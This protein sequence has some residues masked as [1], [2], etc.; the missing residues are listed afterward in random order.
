MKRSLLLMLLSVFASVASGADQMRFTHIT[1]KDGLPNNTV[2]CALR[3]HK[4]YFWYGTKNGLCKWDGNNFEVFASTGKDSLSLPSSNILALFEDSSK[5]LW[6]ATNGGVTIYNRLMGTFDAVPGEVLA[7]GFAQSADGVIYVP[8]PQGVKYYDTEKRCFISLFKTGELASISVFAVAIDAG[9]ALWAGTAK[10]LY[11]IDLKTMQAR[12]YTRAQGLASDNISA[13][14]IDSGRTLWVGTPDNGLCRFDDRAGAFVSVAGLSHRYIHSISEKSEGQLWIGTE[15]GLNVYEPGTGANRIFLNDIKDPNSLSDNSIYC[16]YNDGRD[17]MVVGTYFGGINIH[18]RSYEQLDIFIPTSSPHSIGGKVVRQICDDGR[19]G[20]WIATEDG[21]LNYMD[22][23]TGRFTKYIHSG[24]GSI[25]GDN[26]H[27]VATDRNRNLWVGTYLGGLNRLEAGSRRFTVYNQANTPELYSDNIFALLQDTHGTL[28]IGTTGGVVCYE[29]SEGGFSRFRSDLLRGVSV[30]AITEDSQGNIWLGTRNKGVYKYNRS[31]NSLANYNA[32]QG[33]IPWDKVCNLLAD[34]RGMLWVATQYGGLVCIEIDT[35]AMTTFTTEDGLPSNSVYGVIEDAGGDLWVTSNRGLSKFSVKE[36]IFMTYTSADGLPN[37]QFNYNS[38]Y[39]DARGRLYLGT[40]DGM[41]RIDPRHIGL[42]GEPLQIDIVDMTVMGRRVLPQEDGSPLKQVISET[43]QVTLRSSRA[44]SF[45]FEL[46]SPSIVHRENISFLIQLQGADKTWIDLGNQRVVT[47]ANLPAGDYEFMAK[48]RQRDSQLES[49][50]MSIKLK[51]LPPFWRSGA[52]FVLYLLMLAGAAYA[53]Y[54]IL[55]ARQREK[56]ALVAERLENSKIKE[57]SQLKINFFT[58]I[59]HELRTPLTL[60]MSP[61]QNI[62][63]QNNLPPE[64]KERMQMIHTNAGRMQKLIDELI[65]LSRIESGE[66]RINAVEGRLLPF[67]EEICNG[68][69]LLAREKGISISCDIPMSNQAVFFDPSMVEKIVFN[70]LSNAVKYTDPDGQVR[71][72]AM[73]TEDNGRLTARITVADTGQGIAQEDMPHIFDKYYQAKDKSGK[74]GFGIGLNMVRQLTAAHQGR[75]EVESAP[76]RGSVFTVWLTVDGDCFTEQ[77]KSDRK[78][79]NRQIS[80]YEFLAPESEGGHNTDE[81]PAAHDSGDQNKKHILIVEDNHELL[82]YIDSLFGDRYR[83]TL[84]ADGQQGYATALD[85]I[86][87]MIISDL[88]MPHM[89]GLEF[90]HA[91][92][93]SIE[94]CHVPF[95]LLSAKTGE[96]SQMEGYEQGADEYMEKPFNPAMLTRKVDNIFRTLDSRS[97]TI[98]SQTAMNFDVPD[99]CRRDRELLQSIQDYI[100]THLTE[101]NLPITDIVRQI[102]ISRTLLH[103]KLRKLTGLSTTEFINKIRLNRGAEMLRQ[104]ANISEAA[105]A[106]GFTSP[107]YFSRCFKKFYGKSPR[108]YVNELTPNNQ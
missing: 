61:I 18:L 95:I 54:R 78:L 96:Q 101:E 13:L 36:R 86:P 35:G 97:Q 22:Q 29:S 8:T 24:P 32:P 55:E 41:I 59:S 16:V 52:A 45:S 38:V 28:W 14:F 88:M 100:I 4:G 107:N 50:V 74:S 106:A 108:E 91:A 99:I 27:A 34:D 5:R 85:V 66:H 20:L 93:G 6:V 23:A 31:D 83:T 42:S 82:N 79:G 49:E 2:F 104:G 56:N 39:R 103:T 98:G 71:V 80:D 65:W 25:S 1:N 33:A 10:G 69:R 102:G 72:S 19:G 92:K 48:A 11:V 81:K 15:R 53:V 89:N 30:E 46:T 44:R 37:N 64:L 70:L 68:F 7:R 9:G 84:C 43:R 57:V 17:N 40:I 21:G 12:H 62:L 76:G 26:I 51:V 63:A 73:V 87:D 90:C 105:Y 94:L 75:V 60:V 58:N 77:E 67:V 47:Y 3:D